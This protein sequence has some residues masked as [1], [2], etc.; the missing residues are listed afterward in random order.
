MSGGCFAKVGASPVRGPGI[1]FRG[2]ASR[3]ARSSQSKKPFAFEG[4]WTAT[5][6]GVAEAG[7]NRQQSGF[8]IPVPQCFE[9]LQQCIPPAP[10]EEQN[11][12]V[13]TVAHERV[14]TRKAVRKRLCRMEV[15]YPLP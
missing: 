9:G 4:T 8:F 6:C 1:A 2:V 14:T 10:I 5:G 13:P 11:G 7:S 15:M 12:A 3:E